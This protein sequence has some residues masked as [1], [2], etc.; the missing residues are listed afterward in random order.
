MGYVFMNLWTRGAGAMLDTI[1]G[2]G[3]LSV[4]ADHSIWTAMVGGALWRVRGDR[5]FIPQMLA[6]PRFLRVLGIA[7]VLHMV[8]NAPVNPPFFAKYVVIGFVGWAAVLSLI[9]AGLKE[10]RQA[11]IEAAR[12]LDGA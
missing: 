5:A 10:V 12:R 9:Q 7:I 2:R 4:L 3:W 8:N 1:T 6:D 11:Q